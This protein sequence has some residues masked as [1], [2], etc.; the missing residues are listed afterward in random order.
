MGGLAFGETR[1]R[2]AARHALIAP[3]GHVPSQFPGITGAVVNVLISP[4]MGAAITQLLVTFEA[5]GSGD[6]EAN[7]VESV[8][9][10]EGGGCELLIGSDSH[11]VGAGGFGFVP[12][13]VAWEMRDPEAGTRVTIFQKTYVAL[14]GRD[15]PSAVVG[16]AADVEGVPFLGDPDARLKVLLPETP[17][18]DFGVNVF[19]YQSGA[20]LPFVETHVMEHGLLMLEGEG[21]YRLEDSW[22]PVRAGDAIWMAPYCP[23]WFVAM[24]KG[25]AS[26]VYC[27]DVGRGM[28]P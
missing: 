6:F 24:G 2:V 20:R 16:N 21:I 11:A 4:A 5:G 9:Y 18:F 12:A 25:P 3:D 23:Q 26:Y 17:E 10:V 8:L 22:Y 13:G 15:G 1:T 27:K 7:G 14:E 19:T 28:M